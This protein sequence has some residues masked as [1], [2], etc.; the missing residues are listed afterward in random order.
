MSAAAVRILFVGSSTASTQSTLKE[1]AR[2]GWESHSVQTLQ[3][4]DSVLRT[5]R[6][7]LILATEKLADGTGY[8]L[9]PVVERQGGNLFISVPLSETSLWLPAVERGS[10]SLGERALN[11]VAFATEAES[12]LRAPEPSMDQSQVTRSYRQASEGFQSGEGPA[13]KRAAPP[14]RRIIP[15]T[16]AVRVPPSPLTREETNRELAGVGRRWR[17]L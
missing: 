6:F 3:E 9:V 5:I 8:G 17:G 16:S 14:R 2:S 11:P 10:R 1:L 4:A 12:I 15:G 7:H 13:T